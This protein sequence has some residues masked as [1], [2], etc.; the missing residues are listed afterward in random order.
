MVLRCCSP[1]HGHRL[2]LWVRLEEG[3]GRSRDRSFQKVLRSLVFGISASGLETA[4][5][6][7]KCYF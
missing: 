3:I 5:E 4:K 7:R 1:D 6:E 2:G